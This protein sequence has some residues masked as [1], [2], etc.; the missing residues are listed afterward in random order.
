M[1]KRIINHITYNIDTA[2][3][4]PDGPLW[5]TPGGH[6]FE[7]NDDS[8]EIIP[9]G[10]A[11]RHSDDETTHRFTFRAPA[12]LACEIV[13]AAAFHEISVNTFLMMCAEQFLRAEKKANALDD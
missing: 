4:L 7:I 10:A 12:P 9:R 1:M 11:P 3:K 13:K 8:N 6:L 2:T 5:Q